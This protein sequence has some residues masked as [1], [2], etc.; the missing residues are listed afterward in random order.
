MLSTENLKDTEK[1]SD[2]NKSI[3]T[4]SMFS[5]FIVL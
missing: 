5:C 3:I 4:T 2:E 1:Y